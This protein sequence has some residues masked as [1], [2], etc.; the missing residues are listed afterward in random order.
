MTIDEFLSVLEGMRDRAA[1]SAPPVALEIARVYSVH[2]SRVTLRERTAAIGQFGTPAAP[3]QP[4]AER[5]GALA[6]SVWPWP[7]PSSGT[8]GRAYAGPHVIYGRTQETGAIHEAR[9][10]EFM[11]WINDGGQR[12]HLTPGTRAPHPSFFSTIHPGGEWW[13]KKVFIPPRPY[14]EPAL[15]DVVADGS[16]TRAA[17]LMWRSLVGHY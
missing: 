4:P 3:L 17:A 12:W 5:S 16:L 10:F 6:A 11:H 2:L 7:G 9:N 14:L 1:K 13:K 8:T 15:A